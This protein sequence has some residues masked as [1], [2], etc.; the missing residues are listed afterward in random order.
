M[1]FSL[2]LS[3]LVQRLGASVQGQ[4]DTMAEQAVIT[5]ISTDSRTIRSG[6]LFI[7]LEGPNFDGHAFLDK[8]CEAG[9]MAVLVHR[10][11]SDINSLMIPVI[12]VSNTLVAYQAIAQWWRRQFQGPVVAIT[13][14]VGKTTTKELIA[15]VLSTQGQ[16]L[17]THANYNNEI[18]VPKTLLRL[19]SSHDYAVIE[20]GM[21]GPGEI[22]ELTDITIPDIG[23][24]TN[25]GTAHIG[26]LG[27]R[28]AIARAKCELLEHLPA[29]GIAILN[30]DNALLMETA[31]GVWHGKTITY[32]LT[33]GDLHGNI[34]APDCLAVQGLADTPVEFP[35]PLTGPHN[36][37]NYL[38]ALGVVQALRLDWQPL[39]HGIDVSL[40]SG[41]A[42]QVVLPEDVII[43]DETYNAG[44]ES[45]TAALQLLAATP[46]KRH[47]AVLGTMKELGHWSIDL[48]HQVG[49]MVQTL[50]LDE[51]FVLADPDERQA[52]IS[53][54]GAVPA[55]PCSTPSELLGALKR[56]VRS[57]DRLLFKASRSVK[58][59]QVVAQ[60]RHDWQQCL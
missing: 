23:I 9:A 16:V 19:G 44:F 24:I 28:E 49:K 55:H 50:A 26:R 8:A 57:G 39:M 51:L 34:V 7:A 38:A 14:S 33:G 41:R 53:G 43:L 37:L 20:M 31:A 12:Q 18:G 27:S 40:P 22:A 4:T 17:K 42:Q 35:L 11:P 52:L 30:Q 32:G 29:H 47:I 54:A 36:A 60:F 59:D 10:L 46:G 15:A 3:A 2:S 48:H 45:M 6:D 13:G 5:G 56:S 1:N 58:L 25:V 21:R